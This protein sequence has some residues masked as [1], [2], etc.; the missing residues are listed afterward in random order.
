MRYHIGVKCRLD[1]PDGRAVLGEG[2]AE[3]LEL[4]D[5]HG[6]LALAAKEMGMSYRNA[7]GIVR[8]I[9]EAA[10]S[11]VVES[12]R[13]G[14]RGGNTILTPLGR[15]MVDTFRRVEEALQEEAR[16]GA[17]PHPRLT[18]DVVAVREGR[19]LLVRRGRAPFEGM[20]ALPGGFVD[21]G[22]L[23]EEAALRELRE[24]TGLEGSILGIV[25]VYSRP[26]R[27]PRG[28]TVSVVYSVEAGTGDPMG[29]DDAQEA[30]WHGLGS[31][32]PLAFDH[33]EIL[34]DFRRRGYLR[35]SKEG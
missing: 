9:S 20:W 8:R 13:G 18:V 7:W 3:L 2:R 27:D 28:H 33:G 16:R 21:R 4:V 25:G 19:V 12:T 22:E 32:P 29:S 17:F 15:E 14:K 23:V 11:P 30:R 24:E 26:D 34:E 1:S 31:P 10:G 5:E 6:S 35:T